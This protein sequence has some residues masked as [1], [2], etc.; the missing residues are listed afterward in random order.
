MAQQSGIV[1]NTKS[2]LGRNPD[3]SRHETVLLMDLY[4]SAP[5]AAKTHPEVRALSAL[6]RAAAGR[7]GRK[8]LSSFRNPAGVAMRLRNFGRLD[9]DA[10]GSRDVGLRPGGAVD[11]QVWAEFARA[12]TKLAAKV[13][14]ARQVLLSGK[15]EHA[16]KSSRGPT[17]TFGIRTSTSEDGATG[18]YLLLVDG[19]IEFIAPGSAAKR[20]WS[21][22]KLGRTNDLERRI[23]EIASGLP[24][25]AAVHYVP[26]AFRM[27]FSAADAHRFERQLLNTCDERGWS[28]GGEFA[29]A[30]LL[31]L[32]AA[33]SQPF[34]SGV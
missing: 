20:G 22:F 10:P 11:R 14:K 26:I 4:L 8:I 19:P 23:T 34:V 27:F 30:P 33:M 5:R 15:H 13:A 17:P 18:V 29:F 32:K 25:C 28:L 21:P 9:P 7:E 31:D 16:R 3:W 12:P 6:L 24:A 2:S 1:I